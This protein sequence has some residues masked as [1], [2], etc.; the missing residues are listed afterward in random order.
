M[1]ILYSAGPGNLV[2]TFRFWLKNEDDPHQVAVTYSGQFYDFCKEQGF[3]AVALSSCPKNDQVETEQFIVRNCPRSKFFSKGPLYHLG[4]LFVSV[5]LLLVAL[6][7]RCHVV[8]VANFDDWCFLALLRLFG[9]KIIPSLHC[10]FWA[11]GNRPEGFK[12]RLRFAMSVWFWRRCVTA[13]ICISPECERQLRS[14]VPD[15][16]SPVYQARP[17]YRRHFFEQIPNPKFSRER[18][19]ILCAGRME[20]NKGIIEVFEAA[21]R[22][23]LEKPGIFKWS[24]CGGGSFLHELHDLVAREGAEKYFV[25]NGHV[26]RDRMLKEIIESNVFIVPT[27]ADFSEGLNKVAVEGVLAGR[28]VVS[29]RFVPANEVLQ[30]AVLEL[31]EVEPAAIA[32]AILSLYDDPN[33]YEAKRAGT[34]KV[35]EQ[36]YSAEAGWKAALRRSLAHC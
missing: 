13:T 34:D 6:R 7:H 22:L 12:A 30:D 27:R 24:I 20:K 9:V 10:T 16:R 28:P 26:Q 5:Q 32:E 8:V 36:F 21:K 31:K 1:K 33:A 29:S 14:L 15:L 23:E 25:V 17:T 3:G 11:I 18:F 35:T 19:G 2:G 4:Q